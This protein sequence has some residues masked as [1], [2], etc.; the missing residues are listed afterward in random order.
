MQMN[1]AETLAGTLRAYGTSHFFQVTGGDQAFWVALQREGIRMILARSESG[2]TYMADGYAR[3]SGQPG[4]VY[5]QYGPGVANVAAALAE[6]W[7]AR[8]PVV[9][10]TSSTRTPGRNRFEY[11]EL[12]QLTMNAPVT[13][14]NREVILAERAAPVLRD[15]I[16]AALAQ[17]GGGP[18]H[19]EVPTDVLRG[20]VDDVE[21]YRDETFGM[22]PPHHA[23]PTAIERAV[24]VLRAASRPL[25]LAGAGVVQGGAFAELHRFA[26]ASGIPVATTPGGKGAVAETDPGAVGVAGRYSRTVANQVLAEADAVVV[27]G[28]RLGGMATNGYR[29]PRPEA[30]IIH[31]DI[32]GRVLGVFR[33]ET[34]SVLAD[35]GVALDALTDAVEAS[36]PRPAA[37]SDWYKEVAG[38]MAAWQQSLQ[39]EVRAATGTPIHPV[40]VL[41]ALSVAMGP[42]DVLVADTGYSAAWTAALLP[43]QRAGRHYLRAVGSLGWAVPAALGAQ[44]AAPG[45]RVVAV[46]GDG[47]VGYHL[48]EMETAARSGI[49]A[50]VVVFNNSCLAFEYHEQKLHWNEVIPAANDFLPGVDYAA[51][52]RALGARGERV[53]VPADLGGVL[54]QAR[55][56]GEPTLI[57]VVTD[58]EALAPVTNYDDIYTR[59]V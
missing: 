57:D 17:P 14:F 39:R 18:A 20:P 6:A 21:I 2:A 40:A 12:D 33:R 16:R 8:S 23:D 19:L 34:V 4:F 50:V 30:A 24:A 53:T 31:V 59:P 15:A 44:L 54:R 56:A 55:D 28:S 25:I 49:P 58:R 48:T 26:T 7:W 5:G 35:A 43:V 3:L 52:A 11:Q 9:S 45:R 47:G 22:L 37:W 36:G 46:T 51:A 42:E 27:L 13:V 32:D 1:V 38:R 29:L 10:L 41:D